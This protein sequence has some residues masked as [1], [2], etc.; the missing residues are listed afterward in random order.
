[1]GYHIFPTRLREL[2]DAV[3]SAASHTYSC[4]PAP[5]QYALAKAL[6]QK[7]DCDIYIRHCSR[8]MK[9]VG[10]YCHRWVGDYRGWANIFFKKMNYENIKK[11][12]ISHLDVNPQSYFRSFQCLYQMYLIKGSSF[13]EWHLFSQTYDSTN[14]LELLS[15]TCMC[16]CRVPFCQP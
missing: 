1:M 8:I 7:E 11:R 5:M 6:M 4:A 3:R 13:L 14:C 15:Y 16:A 2:R 10:S 12:F 9:A